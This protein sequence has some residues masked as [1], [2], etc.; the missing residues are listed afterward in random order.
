MTKNSFQ[1]LFCLLLVSNVAFSQVDTSDFA[2]W[3]SVGIDYSPIKKLK[4][5]VEESLRLKEDATV[6]DEYFTEISLQYEVFKNFEIGGGVRFIKENDNVG[7]KQGYESHFRFNFDASYKYDIE[8]FTLSHRIRYQNKKELNLPVDEENVLKETIRFKT[9]IEYNIRKWPLDPSFSLELFS[10]IEEDVQL[11]R[12]LSLDKFRVTFGTDYKFR[13]I[14]KFG[15]FYRYEESIIKYF[16]NE[17]LHVLGL[18][19]TYSIN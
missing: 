15:V 13:K 12:D 17:T 9:G 4:I 6:T 5:G 7:K 11:I 2:I 16:K 14:G 1:T 3:S 10:G 18:K 8:R 19:Y